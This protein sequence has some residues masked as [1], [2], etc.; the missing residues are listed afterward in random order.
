MDSAI[1][2]IDKYPKGYIIWKFGYLTKKID[3][4]FF[5]VDK[6]KNDPDPLFIFSHWKRECVSKGFCQ[7]DKYSNVDNALAFCQVY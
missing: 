2:K 4:G 3:D 1:C 7:V 5:Q 6:D